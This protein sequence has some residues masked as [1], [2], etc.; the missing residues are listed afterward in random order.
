M[1]KVKVLLARPLSGRWSVSDV[2]VE[3]AKHK[4]VTGIYIDTEVVDGKAVMSMWG[5]REISGSK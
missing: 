2:E 1:A 4:N 5:Y 3:A